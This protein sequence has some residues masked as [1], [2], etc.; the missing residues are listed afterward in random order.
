MGSSPPPPEA[1]RPRGR[2]GA[3]RRP[4]R[5]G[6]GGTSVYWRGRLSKRSDA[7]GA[8]VPRQAQSELSAHVVGHEPA[9]H[10]VVTP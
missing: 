7:F 4:R 10:E 2:R 8:R 1:A 3:Q 9:R 6:S 5:G